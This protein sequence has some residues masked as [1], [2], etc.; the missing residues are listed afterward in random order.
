MLNFIDIAFLLAFILGAGILIFLFFRSL[1]RWSKDSFFWLNVKKA[2]NKRKQP[3]VTKKTIS[4]KDLKFYE[5]A[6]L[7]K[8]ARN[9]SRDNFLLIQVF[10]SFMGGG[11]VLS[12]KV[13][14]LGFMD[15]GDRVKFSFLLIAVCFAFFML[16]MWLLI[17]EA[18]KSRTAYLMEIS[19]FAERLALCVT[20]KADVRST[21][22]RAGRPLKLL[23][24]HIQALA[25]KWQ[26]NQQEA[27]YGF[28]EAVGVSEVFTL[29]NA[30]DNISK[31]NPQDIVAV[32][33]D[34]AAS[35]EAT[36]ESDVNRN[37]ENAPVTL[38]FYIMIPFAV[39][40]LI[41][42]YPWVVQVGQLLNTS[43]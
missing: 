43:F 21:I 20:D 12:S 31:A 16:P 3:I 9:I 29:V 15:T 40:L 34:Q 27:I 33:K 28:Q 22:L 30:L 13:Q 14:T 5:H 37:I 25:E 18:K 24:P 39:G 6:R 38:T 19:L 32:L 4:Y 1:G 35:I 23:F 42:I 8:W 26:I 36:L 41:F 10:S 2:I 11:I 7:V 17:A